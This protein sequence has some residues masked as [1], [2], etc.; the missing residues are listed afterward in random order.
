MDIAGAYECLGKTESIKRSFYLYDDKVVLKDVF[1]F[2]KKRSVIERICTKIMPNIDTRGVVCIE[3]VAIKYDC[4]VWDVSLSS[5]AASKN[6][7]ICY[8]I[9]FAA[10]REAAEFEATIYEL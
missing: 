10:K 9:D 2:D 5:E 4:E 3:N 7:T 1:S 6:D 8:M